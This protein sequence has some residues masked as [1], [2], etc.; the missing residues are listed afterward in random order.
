MWL[1]PAAERPFSCPGYTAVSSII[2]LLDLESRKLGT[3]GSTP[4]S[5]H[6]E[7]AARRREFEDGD[8]IGLVLWHWRTEKEGWHPARGS[9]GCTAAGRQSSQQH[10]AQ[11]CLKV[12]TQATQPRS[13]TGCTQARKTILLSTNHSLQVA[14]GYVVRMK[15]SRTA[16]RRTW[17]NWYDRTTTDGNVAKHSKFYAQK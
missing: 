8:A 4:G 12:H 13:Y 16:E 15:V 5:R 11:T 1:V 10:A 3:A 14:A 2:V 17:S 9:P 6:K 7:A